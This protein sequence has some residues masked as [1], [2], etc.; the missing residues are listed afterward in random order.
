MCS[1][2]LPQSRDEM[3]PRGLVLLEVDQKLRQQ[4]GIGAKRQ[5]AD[6][7]GTVG[8]RA[9]Q[10]VEEFACSDF[11]DCRNDAHT[12]FA[13]VHDRKPTGVC[14]LSG[15]RGVSQSTSFPVNGSCPHS[16]D[17]RSQQHTACRTRILTVTCPC[18]LIPNAHRSLE[19]GTDMIV[20]T[21]GFVIKG[22]MDWNE[23]CVHVFPSQLQRCA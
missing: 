7:R 4:L 18:P 21:R 1:G 15:G 16:T 22:S 14:R 20:L 8:L 12:D 2:S 17:Y 19:P 9:S 10:D 5:T 23:V 6:Q 13:V 11:A 3:Q